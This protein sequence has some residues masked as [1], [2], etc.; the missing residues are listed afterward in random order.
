MIPAGFPRFR[1]GVA[2][3]GRG[4]YDGSARQLEA[5]AAAHP[6]D[7]RV[8]EAD[9]LRAVALQRLDAPLAD[10]A[11]AARRYLAAAAGGRAHRIEARQIAG[12]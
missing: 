7:A 6:S 2:A 8:D 5:F 10:A 12:D 9:Y 3:L 1:D 11:A 4:D